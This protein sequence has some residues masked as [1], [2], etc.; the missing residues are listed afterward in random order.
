MLVTGWRCQQA[1]ASD[2]M[3]DVKSWTSLKRH[4]IKVGTD[5]TMSTLGVG[6]ARRNN[7]EKSTR[8]SALEAEEKGSHFSSGSD[9]GLDSLA[10]GIPP[11]ILSEHLDRV[12]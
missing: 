5:W 3:C 8:I 4:C 6:I 7:S 12:Q 2:L 9:L 10:E 1:T 11:S